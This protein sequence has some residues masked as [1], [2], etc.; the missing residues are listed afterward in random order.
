L[1]SPDV[2]DRVGEAGRL[3]QG[4]PYVL[5]VFEPNGDLLTEVYLGRLTSDDVGRQSHVRVLG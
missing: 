4:N 2:V 1:G 3:E 5:V